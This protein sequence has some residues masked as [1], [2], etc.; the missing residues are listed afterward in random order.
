MRHL[1]LFSGFSDLVTRGLVIG[2]EYIYID[3]PAM[4][5]GSVTATYSS[6]TGTYDFSS[7]IA[8]DITFRH[9][10]PRAWDAGLLSF[11]AIFSLPSSSSGGVVWGLAVASMSDGDSSNPSYGTRVNV[12]KNVAFADVVY[13]TNESSGV[14]VGN[15]ASK[16]DL[17]T[18]NLQRVVSDSADTVS[19]DA[20]LIGLLIYCTMDAGTDA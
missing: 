5:D 6:S 2:K 12:S 7:T 10:L 3:A 15:S 20:R 11:K 18:F 19:V 17:L 14:V 8:Q 1:G 9:C 13:M 4:F 16:G